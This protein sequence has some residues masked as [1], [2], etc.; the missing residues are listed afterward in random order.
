MGATAEFTVTANHWVPS[1]EWRLDL[2]MR[3]ELTA[4]KTLKKDVNHNSR[5][6][7]GSVE[8]ALCVAKHTKHTQSYVMLQLNIH[9]LITKLQNNLVKWMKKWKMS[10]FVVCMRKVI[11]P[12]Y[13]FYWTL[14]FIRLYQYYFISYFLYVEHQNMISGQLVVLILSLIK[15][16]VT[17]ISFCFFKLK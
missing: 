5:F 1:L 15:L 13:K 6:M 11:Q 9:L 17:I 10:I 14:S 4:T 3:T 7:D 16:N 8:F 2:S 12:L